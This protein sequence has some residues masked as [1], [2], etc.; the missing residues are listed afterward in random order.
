MTTKTHDRLPL[1]NYPISPRS[2]LEMHIGKHIGR[3]K[4]TLTSSNSKKKIRTEDNQSHTNYQLNISTIAGMVWTGMKPSNSTSPIQRS[5][6]PRDTE[7]CIEE[8]PQSTN[9][10]LLLYH[11]PFNLSENCSKQVQPLAKGFIV[12]YKEQ[13]SIQCSNHRQSREDCHSLK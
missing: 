2:S 9:Q 6:Y 3:A 12:Y 11:P 5:S 13:R 7:D 10:D 8:S 1:E 4:E